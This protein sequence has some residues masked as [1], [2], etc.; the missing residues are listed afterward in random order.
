MVQLTAA[1]V[2]KLMDAALRMQRANQ[3]THP[4]YAQIVSLLRQYHQKRQEQQ[5]QHGN[6]AANSTSQLRPQAP[7]AA[8][9]A[10]MLLLFR[11]CTCVRVC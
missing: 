1:D 2:K 5:Q 11:F 10:G 4:K 3:T 6:G 7:Q 9:Q 8:Q